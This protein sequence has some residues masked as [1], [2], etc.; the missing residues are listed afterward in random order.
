MA[1][2]TLTSR[3]QNDCVVSSKYRV[4]FQRAPQPV[5]MEVEVERV[6]EVAFHFGRDLSGRFG[7]SFPLTSTTL[8]LETFWTGISYDP[9]L[10]G[11]IYVTQRYA[12]DDRIYCAARSTPH[13]SSHAQ[14]GQGFDWVES[15]RSSSCRVFDRL[16]NIPS[17]GYHTH[18][19]FVDTDVAAMVKAAGETCGPRCP[20]RAVPTLAGPARGSLSA[21]TTTTSP[22]CSYLS[23]LGNFVL[24]V[25][26]RLFVGQTSERNGWQGL[27]GAH[28]AVGSLHG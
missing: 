11:K 9:M 19:V 7:V 28:I 20:R 18:V 8:R 2:E 13:R 25:F 16:E 14:V 22:T 27:S 10:L 4:T 6:L 23:T 17:R 24:D 5:L 1:R 3:S 21:F 26:L 12:R 15:E